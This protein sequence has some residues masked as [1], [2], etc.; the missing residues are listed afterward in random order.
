MCKFLLSILF[1]FSVAAARGAT[2]EKADCVFKNGAVYTMDPK[3]PKAE[4]VAVTG[5]KIAYVG[6]NKGVETYVGEDTQ[7]IDLQGKMLLPGFVESHIHPTL[8]FFAGGAD[9]QSDSVDE[10]LARVKAWADA[11]PEA[12]LIRGFGW[13]YTL[14]PTTGPTKEVL[15]KL[16]PDRPV[17]LVAIDV[18]SAWVNSK[19]LELAGIDAKT[20][21][22]VPGV[23][24]FQR[25]PKTGEP[26]GWVVETLAEQ[27]VLAKLAPPT[28]EAV[29]A[30]TAGLMPKLAAAGITAA[31]DAGIGSMPTERGLEAY[32]QMEKE[33]KLPLRIVGCYYWNN[34]AVKD[35]VPLVLAL[36]EKFHSELVQV[37][38]LKIMLDGGE[39]QHTAVMNQPY[40]DRP[41]FNADFTVEQKLVNAAI[42]KAQASGIDTHAHCYGD[43]AVRAYL[44]AVE[45]A[46][47]AHPNSLSRHA[48]A[49][50]IFV[51]DE[52]VARFANLNVT[53][54]SS[55]Q[56]ATPDPTIKRTTE[57]VGEKVAFKEMFRHNSVLKAGG[58]LALGSDWPAAGY[59][60]T[61][62][63]LDAIQVAV[64][65]EILPQ[66]GKDQFT[67]VLPPEDERI[68]L[69]QALK[70]STLDAAY[71]LG[72]E[73]KIGSI[74]TGKLA[75]LVI[76][77]KDL[78]D[79]KP[80]EISRTKVDLTMMNGRVTYKR[81]SDK[82]A[83]PLTAQ[84]LGLMQGFPAP[85]G[86]QVTKA[87]YMFAPYNRWSFQ[88]MRYFNPTAPIE[89]GNAP[90]SKFGA[91]PV[92]LLEKT[93]TDNSYTKKS[94]NLKDLLVQHYTDGFIVIHNGKILTEYYANG[95]TPDTPHW[96]AS[97]TKS[98]QSTAAEI[99]IDRGVLDDSQK[100]EF[101]VPELKGTMVGSAT[102]REVLDMNVCLLYTSPS[103]RD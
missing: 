1:C 73:D 46:R 18:H 38:T 16:F 34:S 42:L 96:V 51:A 94:Y 8:A 100:V 48:V 24:Y 28:L 4:A 60:S 45:Q 56:W 59:V 11:N 5:K 64:T 7:V 39:A 99:L 93:F 71:V 72:L 40:A 9:L 92:N 52:E 91:E 19:A 53:L 23:S 82:P 21:D 63:P 78:H 32:Q 88:H 102:V 54:Q 29:N 44:D 97:M 77:D 101:Y 61:Y 35:P 90:A 67:Q 89:R 84:Q 31:F 65:R 6:D 17:M 27:Q 14:F 41:G 30:A 68:T 86:K 62:R 47:K 75:D 3:M 95:M 15:D 10:V 26:T 33:G 2:A 20:P 55:A 80:E 22:P 12:S 70:A 37:R 87:N 66:Y 13:R 49:H 81:E 57:I 25:D 74:E 69:D 85:E 103:P 36:R 58:R 83:A 43:G 98:V 79:L 76:L 50:A